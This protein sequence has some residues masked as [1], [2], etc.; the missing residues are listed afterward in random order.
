[1]IHKTVILISALICLICFAEN[2]RAEEMYVGDIGKLNVRAGNTT[3]H[4]V[5]TTLLPGDKVEVISFSGGWSQII[6][7]NGEKGWAASRFLTR[8]KPATARI[9]NLQIQM[10]IQR[11]QAEINAIE[12]KRLN[13]EN[14]TLT[15]R[16]NETALTLQNLETAYETLKTGSADYLSLKEKYDRISAREEKKDAEIRSLREKLNDKHLSL[17]IKWALTGAGILLAGFFLGSRTRRK[18]SSLL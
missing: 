1:M 10:E 5:I 4:K 8:R 11:E 17:A 18:R 7:E 14:L 9:E 13:E 3:R 16:L 6:T 12:N 15:T 2:G